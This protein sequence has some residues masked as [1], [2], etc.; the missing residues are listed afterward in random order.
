[1]PGRSLYLLS[2]TGLA[3][4]GGQYHSLSGTEF[5]A[6]MRVTCL[7]PATRQTAMPGQKSIYE[8]FLAQPTTA[9]GEGGGE[10]LDIVTV[11]LLYSWK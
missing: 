1:M 4:L 6:S 11:V 8:T 7:L 5:S 2:T 10:E 9:N 3:A